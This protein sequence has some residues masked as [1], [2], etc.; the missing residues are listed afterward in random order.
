[1]RYLIG[2]LLLALLFP[3]EAKGAN[4]VPPPAVQKRLQAALARELPP[5]ASVR[6]ENW[7]VRIPVPAHAQ[8]HLNNPH[9]PIGIVS[10]EAAWSEKGKPR[11]AYGTVSARVSAS[12]AVV[13]A[14][15]RHG[16]ELNETNTEFQIRD[17]T[18]HSATGYF[19]DR[20]RLAS[21]RAS[22][23][24][25]PGA[26]LGLNNTMAPVAVE[27]G[28]AVDLIHQAG[29]LK[30]TAKVKALQSGQPRNWVRVENPSTKKIFMAKVTAPGEVRLR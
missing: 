11:K 7:G 8:V 14:P 2:F 4:H 23:Y 9:P 13:R 15:I 24:L 26:V 18:S 27:A 5:G 16:E 29:P 25:K 17:L 22:G 19:V 6:F 28:Q 3:L 12:V 21:L 10:F 30:I 20:E 1:M